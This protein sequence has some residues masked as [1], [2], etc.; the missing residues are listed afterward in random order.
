MQGE[1]ARANV[2]TAASYPED[3]SP[4]M[5]ESGYTKQYYFQCRWNSLILEEDTT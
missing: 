3:L 1:T 4:K 5:N 2:E